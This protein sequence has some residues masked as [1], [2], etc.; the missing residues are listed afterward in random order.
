MVHEGS[1]GRDLLS[2]PEHKRPD[3]IRVPEAHD[4]NAVYHRLFAAFSVISRLS[5]E[6]INEEASQ[7]LESVTVCRNDFKTVNT[8]ACGKIRWHLKHSED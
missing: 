2:R 7:E 8:D 5:Q 1:L 6:S 4:A 3:A